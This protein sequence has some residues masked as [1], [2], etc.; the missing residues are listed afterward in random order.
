MHVA[1]IPDG[2]R[3]W[4]KLNGTS[5]EQAYHLMCERLRDYAA[6]CFDTGSDVVSLYLS[7]A[8]N[9][10]RSKDDIDAFCLAE[11]A[12]CSHLLPDLSKK[13]DAK[14][15]IAGNLEVLPN[16]LQESAK[17]LAYA[18]SAN[19]RTKLFLCLAYNPIDE[20]LHAFSKF[21]KCQDVIKC[22]WVSEPVDLL[23][24]T[25]RGE[26][27]S[28]FLPLQ[29]AGRAIVRNIDELFLDTNLKDITHI[30]S[31]CINNK[32]RKIQSVDDL[33]QVNDAVSEQNQ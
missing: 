9:F 17:Q 30:L 28:N 27:A 29:C 22:L 1:I 12:F 32:N 3:R 23:I 11:H 20:I 21:N 7:S 14:V 6:K 10:T 19:A 16:Y 25:G 24:R 5:Y 31:E 18:T 26:R 4:A 33:L 15:I 8:Q 2:L 13:Y